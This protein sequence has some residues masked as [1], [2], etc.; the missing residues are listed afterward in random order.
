MTTWACVGGCTWVLFVA[1]TGKGGIGLLCACFVPFKQAVVPGGFVF[2]S[3]RFPFV[4]PPA[5]YVFSLL[6][7]YDMLFNI[8]PVYLLSVSHLSLVEVLGIF[9]FCF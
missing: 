1:G 3:I 7:L 5:S 2:E 4:F 8:T 6:R 9:L